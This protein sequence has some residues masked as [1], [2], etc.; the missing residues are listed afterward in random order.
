MGHCHGKTLR[1]QPRSP[2]RESGCDGEGTQRGRSLQVFALNSR[3]DGVRMTYGLRNSDP[4]LLPARSPPP[5][6]R[7]LWADHVLV[8]SFIPKS[9]CGRLHMGRKH[10]STIT[11]DQPPDTPKQRRQEFGSS[12]RQAWRGSL[13]THS[14][15]PRHKSTAEAS[16][17]VPQSVLMGREESPTLSDC[18]LHSA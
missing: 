12:G 6:H 11:G 18:S 15:S 9:S 14:F 5:G 13:I 7:A 16:F 4:S 2:A 8:S 1:P 17:L 3:D 10:Q